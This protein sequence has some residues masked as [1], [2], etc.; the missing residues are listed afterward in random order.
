MTRLQKKCMVF[1]LGLHG[2]LVVILFASAGFGNRPDATDELHV[3]NIIPANIVDRAGAGGGTTVVNLAPQPPAQQHVQSQPQPPA[4]HVEQAHTEPERPTPQAHHETT[5]ARP[6]PDESKDLTLEAKPKISKPHPQHEVEVTYPATYAS[7]SRKKSE[8]TKSSDS[9][10]RTQA[11]RLKEIE[12][13]LTDL[14]SGVRKSGSSDPIVDVEG[15]GGGEAFVGYRD[16]VF[17][18]YFRAWITPDNTANR[19]GTVDARVTIA[20]DGSVRSAELVQPS[21]DKSL[22]KSV[23]RVLREVTKLPPF[24]ASTQE[25]ERTYIIRFSLEAKELAG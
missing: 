19:L 8:P 22:D 15:I 1:S 24:P 12:N 4:P 6:T 14:A 18:Y 21:G 5:H 11:K 20:R 23:E 2:L 17:S 7:K 16:V 9:S 3:L 13:S 25:S 10:A